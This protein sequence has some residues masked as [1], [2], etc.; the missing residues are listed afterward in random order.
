[1]AVTAPPKQHQVRDNDVE[2]AKVPPHSLEAERSLLGSM[3]LDNS[4]TDD[5][6]TIV[7]ADDFYLPQHRVIFTAISELY[8]KD[9]PCDILT[10]TDYLTN[11][12]KLEDA[13]GETYIYEIANATPSVANIKAYAQIVKERSVLRKIL[14]KLQYALK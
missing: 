6:I 9:K 3:L 13:G 5:I 7:I 1:M 8:N 4:S 14:T 10:L 12:K 2:R 11:M